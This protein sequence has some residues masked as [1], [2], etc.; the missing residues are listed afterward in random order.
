MPGDDFGDKTEAPTPRRLEEARERGQ[1]ARSTDLTAAIMLLAATGV[2]YFAGKFIGETLLDVVSTMLGETNQTAITAGEAH[3][4]M[5]DAMLRCGLAIAP[6]LLV[7]SVIAIVGSVIQGGF[8]LSSHPLVPSLDKLNPIS[9]FGRIFSK[10]SVA[11]LAGSL[12]KLGALTVVAYVCILSDFERMALLSLMGI[13]EMI[14][15]SSEIVLGLCF[16]MAGVLIVLAVFDYMY[17]RWQFVEDMRMSKQEIREEM[18]RM[19]GDP[20]IKEHRRQM[21]RQMIMH[22]MSREVPKADAVITNP[23]HFAIAIRYDQ[24]SMAAPRVVAKGTD[25]L[26]KRIREIALENGVPIVEKPAL[27]R[28][29]YKAEIGRAHV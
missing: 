14:A 3:E 9:G 28:A 20:M 15:G 24:D 29:L 16:K 12:L 7:L 10:R 13:K 27:A 19:E 5:I 1:L 18:K 6:M 23:T 4:T 2:L 11:R 22:R 21:Q 26:A 17:Q 25:F 8:V